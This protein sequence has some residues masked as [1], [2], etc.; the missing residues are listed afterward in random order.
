MKLL[1]KLK[2]LVKVFQLL[3]TVGD[4]LTEDVAVSYDLKSKTIMV[5]KEKTF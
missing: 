5:K 1:K 2:V 3:E 4:K